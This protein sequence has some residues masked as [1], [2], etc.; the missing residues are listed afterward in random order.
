MS[1]RTKMVVRFTVAAVA[2]AAVAFVALIVGP[3]L[4]TAILEEPHHGRD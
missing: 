2:S 4:V 3:D 1:R